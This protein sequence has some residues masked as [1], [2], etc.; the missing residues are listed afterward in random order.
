M[1]QKSRRVVQY[2]LCLRYIKLWSRNTFSKGR[3][4]G[5]GSLK[6]YRESFVMPGLKGISNWTNNVDHVN[7]NTNL[8]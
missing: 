5:G 4:G 8:L 2:L 1:E 3:E 6:Y 7:Y